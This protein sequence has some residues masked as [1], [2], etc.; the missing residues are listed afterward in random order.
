MTIRHTMVYAQEYHSGV[1]RLG[2]PHLSHNYMRFIG[3][4]FSLELSGSCLSER[5]VRKW[6]YRL[7]EERLAGLLN[8]QR[9]EHISG[10][11]PLAPRVT[12]GLGGL[13][14]CNRLV[15]SSMRGVHGMGLRLRVLRSAPPSTSSGLPTRKACWLPAATATP[16]QLGGG[17]G[18]LLAPACDVSSLSV[19]AERPGSALGPAGPEP[20][21]TPAALAA[22]G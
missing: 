19:T 20:G 10:V 8:R 9:L 16:L 4:S 6:A 17:A 14:V 3:S 11:S 13:A 18:V 2:A 21:D 1:L 22:P 12:D 15:S 7:I 5:H